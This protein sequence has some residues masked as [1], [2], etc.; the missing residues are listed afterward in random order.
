MEESKLLGFLC[1]SVGFQ[2]YELPLSLIFVVNIQLEKS[3]K[4]NKFITDIPLLLLL[5]FCN[6]FTDFNKLFHM[7][8]SSSYK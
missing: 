3:I 1:L 8:N 7:K 4:N 2:L 6:Y 5:I